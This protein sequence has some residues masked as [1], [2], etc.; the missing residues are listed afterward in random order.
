[1]QVIVSLAWDWRSSVAVC[2]RSV[3]GLGIAEYGTESNKEA[4]QLIAS[5]GGGLKVVSHRKGS[6]VSP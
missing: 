2:S 3:S 1:M 6:E 5:P 4:S